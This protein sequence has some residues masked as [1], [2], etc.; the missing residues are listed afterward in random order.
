ML[1]MNPFMCYSKAMQ[2]LQA[3]FQMF[4]LWLNSKFKQ[5]EI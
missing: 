2:N 5:N 1:T 4:V 3:I